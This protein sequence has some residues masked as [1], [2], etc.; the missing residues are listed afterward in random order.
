M[1]HDQ[2]NPLDWRSCPSCHSSLV[3][4]EVSDPIKKFCEPDAFY[5]KL[6][7]GRNSE[8]GNIEYWKC[9]ECK[10]VYAPLN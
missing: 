10:T 9:P 7:G 8:T 5:S 1:K 6:I 2:N 4:A 3:D